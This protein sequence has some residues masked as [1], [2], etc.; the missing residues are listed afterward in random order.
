MF[1]KIKSIQLKP[2]QKELLI[3]LGFI[4][5]SFLVFFPSFLNQ[6][7]FWDDERFVFLNPSVLQAPNWYSFWI[8][9]SDFHKSWP[10]GY[11]IFWILVKSKQAKLHLKKYLLI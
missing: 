5:I 6:N 11:S 4:T 10:L 3:F 1:E 8:V 7:F 9:K 2:Y